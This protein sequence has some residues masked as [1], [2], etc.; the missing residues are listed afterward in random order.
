M[1]IRVD[2]TI[3]ARFGSTRLPGKVLLPVAG[4]PLLARIIERVK[5]S[6]LIDRIIVA[7]SDNNSD[8]AIERL[9]AEE[10]VLC[11][12]GS[13]ED[14]LSRVCG[15]LNAYQVDVHVEL[16]GDNALPDPLLIDSVVGYFLKY[17][18]EVD[19]VSTALKTTFPPGTEV[20]VYAAETLYTADREWRQ[21]NAREHVGPHI[22]KRPDLFRCVGIEAPSWLREPEMHFEVD[23]IEDYEVVQ[24]LYDHFLPANPGFGLAE[25]ITFARASAIHFANKDV[26]RRWRAYRQD[27][28]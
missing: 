3:Q 1:S 28:S 11:F 17:R 4:R 23:A 12:R 25:A 7:T 26:P 2:A 15:A 24:R 18:G 9:A 20:S 16:Q 13:E 22:Y 27:E 10:Q 6:R 8:D 21:E 14:V 19:Y 5:Q